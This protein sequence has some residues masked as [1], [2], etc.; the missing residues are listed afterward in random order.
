MSEP[1]HADR[2]DLDRERLEA[3]M[4]EASPRELP[5]LVR[6]HRAVLKELAAMEKPKE[7]STRDQL[8]A[9]RAARTS[10]AA[11]SAAAGV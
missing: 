3:A 4:S 7:G 6:E 1:S 9:K 2:L 8:A 5:A 11:D 10:R